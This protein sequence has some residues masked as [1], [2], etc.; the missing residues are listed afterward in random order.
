MGDL[1]IG[2]S[3]IDM[4]MEVRGGISLGLQ[5]SAS[6]VFAVVVALSAAQ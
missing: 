4:T 5:E 6:K 3:A 1:V 2:S